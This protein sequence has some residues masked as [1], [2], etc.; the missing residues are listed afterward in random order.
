MMIDFFLH[1]NFSQG[2]IQILVSLL[3]LSYYLHNKQKSFLVFFIVA[4]TLGFQLIFKALLITINHEQSIADSNLYI[5]VFL[6]IATLHLILGIYLFYPSCK[7]KDILHIILGGVII[8]VALLEFGI[9]YV[10][11]FLF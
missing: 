2:V 3:F 9:G 1:K 11:Y 5:G 6:A 10:H 8:F 4:F 7:K